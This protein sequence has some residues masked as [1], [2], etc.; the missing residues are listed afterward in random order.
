VTVGDLCFVILGQIVNRNFD[1]AHYAPSLGL[2]VNSPTHSK[3]L[4]DV[5]RQDFEG[6]TPAQHKR[7]LIDD[8]QR[9]DGEGRRVGAC[10]RTAY[11]F[12]E[13]LE[14][15]VLRQ[16]R[17]PAYDTIEIETFVRD[18]LYNENAPQRCKLLFERFIQ[19]RGPQSRDGILAEL[20]DKLYAQQQE[21]ARQ[22]HRPVKEKPTC[23]NLLILLYGYPN[24]VTSRDRPYI[25][26]WSKARRAE[27]VAALVYDHNKKTDFAVA[28]LL[29]TTTDDD[30][31]ALACM[32][33]LLGRGYESEIESYCRRRIGQ[34]Q[35]YGNDLSEI[36]AK[37][38]KKT[39]TTKR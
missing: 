19:E 5:A 26:T 15:L 24:A 16:L 17:V 37:V 22:N 12:P 30:Y 32:R 27:F 4:C 11:Y 9:P 35:Y 13:E 38:R 33:R 29:R 21:E 8:F 3:R 25:D 36:L 31:L 20:F 2:E 28:D 10:L 7:L 1:A 34:S 6:F 23:R 39:S 14:P 18:R